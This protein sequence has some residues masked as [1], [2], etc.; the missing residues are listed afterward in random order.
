M[1]QCICNR[2]SV[3]YRLTHLIKSCYHGEF[4]DTTFLTTHFVTI[5]DTKNC[6]F[7]HPSSVCA[8]SILYTG[9]SP[10]FSKSLTFFQQCLCHREISGVQMRHILFQRGWI[11][12]LPCSMQL[13]VL[14]T[15]TSGAAGIRLRTPELAAN[16]QP[17]EGT[18]SCSPLFSYS[19]NS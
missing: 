17:A 15:K 19:I 14:R 6:Y 4:Y 3:S 16:W 10:N 5:K 13:S 18:H 11:S 8:L 12:S 7:F 9:T 2:S 1:R